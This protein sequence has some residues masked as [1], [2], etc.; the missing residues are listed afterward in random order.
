MNQ[1]SYLLPNRHS[2]IASVMKMPKRPQGLQIDYWGNMLPIGHVML[3]KK[4]N[5]YNNKRNNET[6]KKWIINKP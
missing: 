5:L 3:W 4:Q 1:G 6:T 2:S